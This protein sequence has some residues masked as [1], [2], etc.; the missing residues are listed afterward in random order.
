MEMYSNLDFQSKFKDYA[1]KHFGISSM[2][3][4]AWEK[5]QNSLYNNISVNSQTPYI[6]EE[7]KLNVTQ[8]DIFS[9]LMMDRILY[10]SGPVNDQMSTVVSSQLL[11]LASLSDEDITVYVDGPGG[12]VKAGLTLVD[13]MA[14]IKPD[15]RTI[16]TGMA[17]SMSSILLGAGTKGKRAGL[18]H[19]RV[20]LHQVSGKSEGVLADMKISL[21]EAEKYNNELFELLGEYCNKTPNIIKKDAGRDL[22]LSSDEAL[23]YG[24]IDEVLVKM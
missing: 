2:Q 17:A 16:N 18:K 7:R 13:T 24:I 21:D 4:F 23:K 8:M 9:R 12:S 1:V 10:L 20:M 22:W 5:V 15:I 3:F 14:L 19:S 6:I 11:F